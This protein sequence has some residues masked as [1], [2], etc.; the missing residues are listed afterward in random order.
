MTLF[1]QDFK[2]VKSSILA[3]GTALPDHVYHQKQAAEFMCSLLAL[4]NSRS[5]MLRTLYANSAIQKRHVVLEDFFHDSEKRSFWP[6]D[7]AHNYPCMTR[8][9][10]CYKKLAPPLAFNAAK[11][12]LDG[13]G[14]DHRTISHLISVSCTGMVAPGIEFDLMQSLNLP[15]TTFRLGINF[16]GCFG[17]FKGL[18]VANALAKENLKHRVLVVCTELCSLHLQPDLDIETLTANALFADGAAACIVGCSSEDHEPRLWE[19]VTGCSLGLPDSKS[20]MSWEASHRGFLMRLSPQVPVLVRREIKIFAD[21]LL[22]NSLT[23]EQLDW[24][25]HPGGKSILQA[26]ERSLKLQKMQTSA[27]WETLAE[28]GN[29]SSA[30][31]LFVLKKLSLQ[32][33][34]RSWTAGIG[35]GPGLSMEGILLQRTRGVANV[36][37]P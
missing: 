4:D 14:G 33:E 20:R 21:K 8:R 1:R 11:K 7:G 29:I 2:F 27:S 16:M 30:S 28:C 26:I 25:I 6:K 23:P 34:R 18:M 19:I 37:E 32:Q 5:A 17:A 3:I 12:A 31:F 36:D 22:G 24:A 10:E 9:N 35:L 13:W 15:S